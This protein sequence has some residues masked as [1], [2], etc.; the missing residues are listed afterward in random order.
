MERIATK[1]LNWFL[2]TH[3]LLA[4]EQTDFRQYRSTNQQVAF[5]SQAIKGALDKSHILTVV[6]IDLKSAYD[7]LRIDNLLLKLANLGIKNNMFR[8]FQGFLIQRIFKVRYGKG[9]S[10]YGVLKTGLPQGSV[11]SC[12]LFNI[13]INEL[14]HLLKSVAEVKCLL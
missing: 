12:T 1:R 2:E 4:E 6:F 9:F 14:V 5:F 11:H 7:T 3:S 10:K 13:Y 8:W